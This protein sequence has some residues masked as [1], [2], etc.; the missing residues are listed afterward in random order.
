[1]LQVVTRTDTTLRVHFREL[2]LRIA[3]QSPQGAAVANV[4]F[5]FRCDTRRADFGAVP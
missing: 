1:M 4:E 5:A 3:D 2:V